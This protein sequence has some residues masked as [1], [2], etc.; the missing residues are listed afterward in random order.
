MTVQTDTKFV[1]VS[2]EAEEV[3]ALGRKRHERYRILTEFRG[4]IEKPVFN[5]QGDWVYMPLREEDKAIIPKAAYRRH[6]AV[7]KAGFRIAQVII[8]HEVEVVP[9]KPIPP[10][11]PKREIDWGNVADIAA[12]GV[13][14]G[15]TGIAMVAL[16]ALTGAFQLV[17]PSYCIVLDDD[18]QGT[19][20][21]LIRWNAQ[22]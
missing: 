3:L 21:E 2:Q 5:A 4:M 7:E 20:I 16:Y 1:L 10:P 17:D 22:A 9:D 19:V 6:A 14:I 8:G 11:K 13:L 18:D 15:I 12:R